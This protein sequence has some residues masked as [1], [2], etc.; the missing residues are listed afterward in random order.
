MLLLSLPKL[1]P[2]QITG[3]Y[4]NTDKC[5]LI[6]VVVCLAELAA[7]VNLG[8]FALDCAAPF[9]SFLLV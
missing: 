8:P 7:D 1:W 4:Q 3:S 2:Y 5:L 6:E 9:V